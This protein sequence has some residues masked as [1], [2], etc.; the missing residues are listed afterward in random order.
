[1]MRGDGLSVGCTSKTF[2]DA[3]SDGTWMELLPGGHEIGGD[4][5]KFVKKYGNFD[6][7]GTVQRR[8]AE[9]AENAARLDALS[10][11]KKCNYKSCG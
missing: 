6:P 10:Q 4:M 7:D 9:A 8:K 3:I 5:R 11:S 1:M 2:E